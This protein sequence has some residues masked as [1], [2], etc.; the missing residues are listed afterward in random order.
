MRAPIARAEDITGVVLRTRVW[1]R[2]LGFDEAR[3]AM[4]ATAVSELAHN[5][6]KYAGSGEV[7]VREFREPRRRGVEIESRDDGPGIPDVDE[8]LRDHVSTGGTLGLGLPGVRRMMDDFFLESKPDTGT[9][10]TVRKWL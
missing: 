5:I 1:C 2:D 7:A 10:V 6:V 8:A 3:A 4:I 9:R